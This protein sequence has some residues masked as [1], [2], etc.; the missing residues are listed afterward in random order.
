[1]GIEPT[2]RR[3]DRRPSG[4]EDRGHHQVYKHFRGQRAAGRP[5]ASRRLVTQFIPPS[6][7]GIGAGSAEARA[8]AIS[9]SAATRR[10]FEILRFV[11]RAHGVACPIEVLIQKIQKRRRVAALP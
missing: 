11:S 8:V 3:V 10:R 2:E 4:F 7:R 5:A 1:M 6:V 9:R